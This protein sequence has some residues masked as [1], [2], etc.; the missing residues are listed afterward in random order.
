M[1]R[2][3]L[4]QLLEIA[5]KAREAYREAFANVDVLERS[6]L[7]EGPRRLPHFLAQVCHETAG[8][9]VLVENLN[10]R[11][12]RLMEVWPSRFPSIAA[13]QP[14]ALQPKALANHVYGGRMGNVD[15]DDGW[16][17][18]GRGLLQLTGR[19]NYARIG[20]ALGLDLLGRPY[21]VASA[22]HALAIAV[23]VWRSAGCMA[24]AD[25]DDIVRVTKAINGGLIGLADRRAWLARA[26][27]VFEVSEEA[28]G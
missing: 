8:L 7:L 22:E 25:E 23:E 9:T 1:T 27:A 13:A 14:Y 6:G 5:P 10:Y 4:R 18:V 2:F 15:P 16:R 24:A 21:L 20:R 28:I 17:Y 11:A 3:T 12:E 26:K 19:A